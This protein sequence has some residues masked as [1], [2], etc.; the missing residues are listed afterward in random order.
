MFSIYIGIPQFSLTHHAMVPAPGTLGRSLIALRGG[1]QEKRGRQSAQNRVL[2]H[3]IGHID[4]CRQT[5]IMQA[6]ND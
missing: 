1:P 4:T 2:R 6:E 5:H 3:Q